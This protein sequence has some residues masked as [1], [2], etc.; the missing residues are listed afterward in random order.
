M[1]QENKN[2]SDMRH[3]HFLNLTCDKEEN[4]RQRH[5][6]LSFLKFDMRHGDPPSRAPCMAPCRREVLKR[7]M[8]TRMRRSVFQRVIYMSTE[9]CIATVLVR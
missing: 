2:D 1:R 5:V 7:E 3:A 8:K 9:Y 4:K 6:T